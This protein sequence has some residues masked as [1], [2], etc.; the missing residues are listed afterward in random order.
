[1][2]AVAA[3]F[4][5]QASTIVQAIEKRLVAKNAAGNGSYRNRGQATPY[6]AFLTYGWA[7]DTGD[8]AALAKILSYDEKGRETIRVLHASMPASIRTQYPTPEEFIVFLFLAHTLLNPVPG[9]DLAEKFVATE[10]GPGQA[11]VRPPGARQGGMNWIQTAEG[12]KVI[13]PDA[14]PENW[15]QQVFGQR[16]AG[17]QGAN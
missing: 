6:E 16:D 17:K 11:V 1:M 9:A 15:V 13:V 5:A 7:L 8:A 10:T 2:T 14:L 12:W 4:A 3:E